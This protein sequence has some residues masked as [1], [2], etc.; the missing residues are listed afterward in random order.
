M[1]P[2]SSNFLSES[3]ITLPYTP[4]LLTYL[5]KYLLTYLLPPWSRVLLEKLTGFAATQEIPRISRTRKFITLLTSA[6]HLSLSW[7]RSIQ[8]PQPPPTSWISILILYFH[9]RLVSP[10]VSFP[11]AYPPKPCAH[12]SPPHTCHTPIPSH[13]SRFYHPHN[14]GQEVQITKLLIM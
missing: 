6:R 14:I 13:S 7:A 2:T 4:Y 11:Q 5:L 8:P 3:S 9:L 12:L 1:H 10:V